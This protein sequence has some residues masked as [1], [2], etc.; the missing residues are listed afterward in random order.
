MTVTNC[1]VQLKE[2]RTVVGY[3]AARHTCRR[4][5]ILPGLFLSILFRPLISEL[6]VQNSTKIGHMVGSKCNLKTHVQNLRYPPQW[7]IQGGS[8][9]SDEPPP[10]PAGSRS[11]VAENAR[12]GCIRVVH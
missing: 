9:G 5:Y 12:T 7:R 2:R 3:Y 4:T 6:A 10:P 8:L 11:V 1:N